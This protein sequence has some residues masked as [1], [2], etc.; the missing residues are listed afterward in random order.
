MFQK[1]S[2]AYSVLSNPDR[3][4]RYDLYGETSPEDDGGF[5][6]GEDFMFDADD[7]AFDEFMKILEMDNMKSFTNMFR[8]LG[9]NYRT[10]G[11]QGTRARAAKASKAGKGFKNK[12]MEG[13][14]DMMTMMMMGEMMGDMMGAF[15]SDDDPIFYKKA[16]AK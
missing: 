14:E 16:G 10:G 4:K 6:F 2:E 11:K 5:D 9:K 7:E 13:L 8:N 3:R 1:I 12:D 15:D